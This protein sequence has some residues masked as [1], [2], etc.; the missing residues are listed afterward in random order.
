MPSKFQIW[1]QHHI[2]ESSQRVSDACFQQ[3][4]CS[5]ADSCCL[6]IN[7][8]TGLLRQMEAAGRCT[9]VHTGAARGYRGS[10]SACAMIR[11]VQCSGSKGAA[12]VDS[13]IPP[14]IMAGWQLWTRDH[15][16]AG[17]GGRPSHVPAPANALGQSHCWSQ[18]IAVSCSHSDINLPKAGGM[19]AVT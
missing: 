11:C 13:P 2:Q 10:C 14:P 1:H 7:P 3:L 8:C 18:N 4:D 12:A 17:Y 15:D 9:H 19:P 16:P 5:T 6:T